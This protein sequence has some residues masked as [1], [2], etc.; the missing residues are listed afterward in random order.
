M[1]YQ[2]LKKL[3]KETGNWY[4]QLL[5]NTGDIWKFEGSS[6]RLAMQLLE[7]GACYLP[8][9]VTYDYYGNKLPTRHQ[10]KEGTKGSY[11][12]SVNYYLSLNYNENEY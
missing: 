12:N 2:Q 7:I 4:Y 6:G 8:K 1:N 11:Q 5:I 10:V 3:Q 9:V